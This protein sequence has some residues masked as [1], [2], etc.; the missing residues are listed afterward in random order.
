MTSLLNHLWQSSLFAILAGLLT[1]ALRRNS[2]RTR[3]WLWF[4]ASVKFF[5]PFSLLVDAGSRVEWRTAPA[6]VQPAVSISV[7]QVFT[8]PA[9][10]LGTPEVAR[11]EA[12]YWPI[13]LGA[14]WFCGFATVLFSWTRQWRRI[15]LAV[16]VAKPYGMPLP[17][18]TMLSPTLLEPGVFGVLRP[19]LLLPEGIAERLM[20]DQ[21]EAIV[22][23][24]MCHV[25]SRDNL[26][27]AVHMLV[28]AIFWVH[29]LVWW[30]GKRLV[31]ERERACD[32]EVLR[33][34]SEPEVYAESILKVCEFY[35]ESPLDCVSGITGSDLRKRIRNIMTEHATLRLNAGRKLLLAVAA[36]A[37]VMTPIVIGALNAPGVLAQSQPSEALAFEVASVKPNKSGSPRE[38]T[39]ILPGGRFTA[40]NNTVRALILNAYGIFSSPYLLLGGPS[41]IDSERY[42][43][44]AR[45][46]TNAIPANAPNKVLWEKTRLMLRTLLADR[47]HLSVRQETKE[48]PVY[49]LVVSKNGP[50][51]N[52]SAQEQ[53]CDALTAC[54]GFSGNPMRLTGTGVDMADLVLQLSYRLGRPVLDK[55]GIQ[56]LFDIKLQW[57][58]FA[59]RSRPAGDTQPSPAAEA[60]DGP[61]PDPDTLPAVFEA[62]EQQIGL[63]LVA[64]KG[65]ADVFV[66]EHVERPSDNE[67]AFF[68][69]ALYSPQTF[70][71]ASVKPAGTGDGGMK[72]E[73]GKGSGS[74]FGLEHRRLDVRL[75]LYGLIVNAYSLRG[76]R[77][78]GENGGC[79]LLSGGPDWLRKD[80]F[81]IVAKVP[82]NAPDYT[83]TQFVNLHA[84]QVQLML[85][86]LLADRFALKIHREKKELPVYALT[87]GKKGVKFKKSDGSKE[88][89]LMFRGWS[90]P[91]GMR[92][93]KLIVEN[94]SMQEL[95]DLYA[96]FMDRPLI[97]KTGLQDRYDFMVDYEANPE[98]PS[99]FSQLSGPALF[100]A[101]EEQAGLKREAS[102]GQVE[103][104]VI[105]H[106]EKPSGN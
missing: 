104:L 96:K 38:P 63:K 62:L 78:I 101:L 97:D 71:V 12:N 10:I 51:L 19:V 103:I 41:W 85:Q 55:T 70:E 43:V 32:E 31:D 66:V 42:D 14:L 28:E 25:R 80:Q 100:K 105:D 3:Y 49:E 77:P 48:M 50:K 7:E 30:I 84:P 75:N 26:A 6:I 8:A 89:R 13:V 36:A 18:K 20:P 73:D 15:R 98:T 53:D 57:N 68:R 45:A 2:A 4:A 81:E 11:N 102:K 94:G 21:L 82:D 88:P 54:H 65:P 27:A 86:A 1:L 95:A 37:A 90:A 44:E 46:E 74:R 59:G 5:I 106:A 56:G 79:N 67:H 87:I 58:P 83:S 72:S 47:F 92:M 69:K 9:M 52:K 91:D 99:P 24:E 60:R 17:I 64:A 29:P 61:R 35:L 22:A 40:T 39:M 93:I 76:C 33:L 23:H 34:G 16:R